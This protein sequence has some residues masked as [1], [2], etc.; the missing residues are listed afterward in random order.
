MAEEQTAARWER[1]RRD[2]EAGIGAGR[3]PVGACL[4]TEAE[5]TRTFGVSRITVRRALQELRTAGMVATARGRRT[6]VVSARP[7]AESAPQ[8]LAGRRV[9]SFSVPWLANDNVLSLM[10]GV[11]EELRLR[12]CTAVIT[13]ADDDAE[14]ERRQILLA[15]EVGAAG[16][17]VYPAQGMA[18]AGTFGEIAAERLPL[19]YVGRHHPGVAAD[20]VVADNLGGAA[21]AVDLLVRRGHSRIAFVNGRER[22]VSAVAERLQGYCQAHERHGLAVDFRLVLMDL[23]GPTQRQSEIS[24]RLAALWAAAA[25]TAALA[26]NAA[27][28]AAL[29]RHLRA[30]N[31]GCELAAFTAP[32]GPEPGPGL[33]AALPVPA[34][35]MG[36][37]A[38]RLLCQRLDGEWGDWPLQR[39]VPLQ[40]QVAEGRPAG[41]RR[42]P[43]SAA[44]AARTGAGPV[45]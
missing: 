25:P 12:D 28:A 40:L 4:P 39:V 2:L 19:V 26:V 20:R 5:L 16:L 9:V 35:A 22:E 34:E 23:L 43:P 36:R 13:C 14:R 15:K 42:R 8:A 45:G 33:L 17:I 32:G 30:L 27:A 10:R 21:A 6:Q 29:E 1:L 37:E 31:L 18:N 7:R 24:E 11:E 41:R 38:A 3:W 44:P